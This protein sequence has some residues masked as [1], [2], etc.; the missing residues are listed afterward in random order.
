MKSLIESYRVI[1]SQTESYKDNIELYIIT[2]SW[3]HRVLQNNPD[4]NRV[5]HIHSES[6]IVNQKF[7]DCDQNFLTRSRRFF[8]KK[9][10]KWI[11]VRVAKKD[12]CDD[13]WDSNITACVFVIEPY[14]EYKQ[15]LQTN[16]KITNLKR[17]KDDNFA[18]PSLFFVVKIWKICHMETV[19]LELSQKYFYQ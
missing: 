3:C 2:Q 9:I 15:P 18:P 7:H 8:L 1:Q 19:T 11:G 6:Y 14:F 17:I 4:S 13:N 5:L 12:L 16:S 10:P